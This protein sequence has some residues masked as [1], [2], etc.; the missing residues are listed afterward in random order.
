M[1]HPRRHANVILFLRFTNGFDRLAFS[2]IAAAAQTA[3]DVLIHIGD[4]DPDHFE[5]SVRDYEADGI[6]VS[7]TE[8]QWLARA[9]ASGKPCVN[10]ANA[11]ELHHQVPVVG[12]DDAAV[13][14]LVAEHY[15][16]RG[17]R[18]FAYF[19]NPANPY[20][21]PRRDAFIKT[22]QEAGYGV[23]VG[24]AVAHRSHPYEEE[25]YSE[26]AGRWL[27]SLP[28]PL[29]VM[30]A[31]DTDA[32]EAILACR[33]AGLRVPED[34][35]IIGVDNDEMLCMTIW[36]H[37]SSVA[38]AAKRIGFEALKLMREM[39]LNDRPA[40][41]TPMLFAPPEIIVR[42][43]SSETA[44]EDPEVAM[45]V[46]YIQAHVS[47]RLSV[48]DLVVHTAISRRALERRF[49]KSLGRTPMDEVRRVRV[50][51]AKRLLIETDLSLSDVA[52]HSGMVR[53]QRL[54][55]VIKA[56]TGQ[57]PMQFRHAARPKDR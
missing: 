53:Q 14:R 15:L 23:A 36:P 56:D 44:V 39:I 50:E 10:I 22:L 5:S 55:S 30:S 25:R 37:L 47:Q 43:S 42:G 28:R 49:Y 17:F 48:E 9:H 13:G 45:A 7:S 33:T 11:L 24:P 41:A 26:S 3:G 52:R 54:C 19:T 2:G 51:R 4:A 8:T 57:T 35:S 18:H 27:A 12:N 32:R 16:D 21:H 38:T 46:N 20:F 1:M 31:W 34:V 6:I 29:A 40:P